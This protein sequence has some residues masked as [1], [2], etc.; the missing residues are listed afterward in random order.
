M[1]SRTLV[2]FIGALAVFALIWKALSKASEV[3]NSAIREKLEKGSLVIDV[4]TPSEFLSGHCN[5]A[6]NIPVQ[7]LQGRLSELGDKNQPIVVYCASGM[8]SA[9]A[10]KILTQAGFT[11]VINAG[12]ARR[13]MS[14]EG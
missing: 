9:M 11:D 6:K 8:R 7:E 4:R 10:A 1:I 12:T 2:I 14:L 13:M 5:S 3:T